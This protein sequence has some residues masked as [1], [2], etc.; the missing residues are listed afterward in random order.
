[1]QPLHGV[2]VIS[3]EQAVAAPFTTRQLADLG[4]RVIKIERPEGDFARR[5]D[6]SVA[7]LS[8]YF[9]WLNRGKESVALDLKSADDLALVRAM[10]AQADVFV[11]NLAPGATDRL[12]LADATLHAAHPRLITCNISGYGTGSSYDAKKAYDL[13]I[14]CEAG[15]VDATG[16]PAEP[17]K[18]GFSV[19]DV[20]AGMY[21][22]SGILTALLA[23][24]STGTGATV[25]VAMLDALAEWM[26]QPF[27]YSHYRQE[28]IGRSGPRHATIA[29]YGPYR[30]RNG[31]VF[32]AVQNEREW[33]RLCAEV[34][35]RPDLV[36]DARFATN[37]LRVANEPALRELMEAIL[38]AYSS[39]ELVARLDECGIANAVMRSVDELW[40]HPALTA[41]ARWRTVATQNGPV[42][43]LLPPVT[44]SGLTASMG[45]VPEIGADTE[46][47]RA[48]F[49]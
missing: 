41:R 25:D 7:G 13:L 21:A 48:E 35:G 12:G 17:V 40:Q 22:Y 49:G 32:L 37:P 29:P 28:A 43:A 2:T 10:L 20:C 3:L 15:L 26:T 23:R 44:I 16:T 47:I 38:G 19:A 8:S 46:R 6:T 14:Q 4:A 45:S 42:D 34:L 18:V 9:V 33:H 31:T 24:A 36:A 1:M 30:A 39:A 11:Q 27:L 5:Y